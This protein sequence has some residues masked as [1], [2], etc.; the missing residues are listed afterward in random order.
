MRT[1]VACF[2]CA[3]SMAC[4]SDEPVVGGNGPTGGA[5]GSV[6]PTGGAGGA[7]GAGGS[8]ASQSGGEN[9]G[10]EGTGGDPGVVYVDTLDSNRDRLL[11]AYYEYLEA[12]VTVPQS[13][14]LSSQ[15]VDSVCDVWSQLD[16]SAQAVFLTITARLQGSRLGTDQSSMLWH[17][18]LLYRIAGGEGA[19]ALDPG[20]C[21]GGEF[22]RMIMRI[23]S[24]LHT[25]LLAAYEHQ[26]ELQPNGA[27]DIADAPPGGTFWRDTNDLGGTHSPFDFSNE[28]D[29]GAP[30]AQTQYFQDPTSA[31]ANA[32]LGRQDLA[33]L[34]DPYAMEV[35]QD[36]NCPHDS[37]PLCTY[38]TYGPLCFPETSK[39]GTQIFSEKYGDYDPGWSPSGCP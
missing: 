21:G 7:L 29:E 11:E 24:A 17:V 35:D 19:T 23:D 6:T 28:T 9:A 2:L 27:Y 1:L 8:G 25:S 34:V 26:G 38:T 30:R 33:T 39:V 12:N 5:G 18:E 10:G 36:Y 32:P 15:N 20:S 4:S 31:L 3:T 16:P 13:N 37:N 14:G 22:N